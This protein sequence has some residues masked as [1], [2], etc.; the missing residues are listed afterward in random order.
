MKTFRRAAVL[1]VGL[2]LFAPGVIWAASGHSS[3]RSWRKMPARRLNT[4]TSPTP[5]EAEGGRA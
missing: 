3:S 2:V 5:P 4:P 1:A